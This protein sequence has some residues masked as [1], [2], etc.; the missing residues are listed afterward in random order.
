MVML[1]CQP[2]IDGDDGERSQRESE[3]GGEMRLKW[4]E[5]IRVYCFGL[6]E[7]KEGFRSQPSDHF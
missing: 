3:E 6:K 2:A 5:W 4:K 1:R 7:E